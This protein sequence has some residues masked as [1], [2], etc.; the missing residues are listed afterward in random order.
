MRSITR[1]YFVLVLFAVLLCAAPIFA[2]TTSTGAIVGKAVDKTG[3][4]I[5]GVEV[6]ISSPAM[7]GG[8]RNAPTDETGSYRFTL[9]VAGAY[10]VSF[11]LPGF[12]TL[13]ID[14]VGVTPGATMTING[15]ME[16]STVAEEVTVTSETPA[17]DLQAATVGVNWEKQKLDDLPW[18]RSVVSLAQ[19]VPGIYVTNYDVGGNQMGGSSNI[20]GRVYG[21]SGGEVRTYDGVAWCMGFDDYGSYEEI[22]LSAAA[23]GAEAMSPGVLA[24]YVVKS[25]GNDFHGTGLAS[26]EDGSFQSSNVDATLLKDG[27]SPGSNNFTRY[28]QFDVDLGGPLVH[29]KLWFYGAYD[30]D[31]SGQYIA[32]FVSQATNAPFVYPITLKIPT[33]KLSYQLSANM[34]L[35]SMVQLSQKAAPYRTGSALVPAE[36]TQSQLTKTALGPTLKWTYIMSPKMTTEVGIERAGYWWPTVPHVNDSPYHRS[37][38]RANTRGLSGKLSLGQ[39]VGSGTVRGAG[40]PI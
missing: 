19:M 26:W 10:R 11:G 1:A 12:K 3:A 35:E 18:G 8:S 31:Y 24:T 25:G 20:G 16:V 34:K 36:A 15:T 17:I 22:Q 38:D 37:D 28:N 29:N 21:R 27:F 6:T 33:V 5:P 4:V 14:N 39:S 13:N 7:I 23:K 40:S 30:Y 2:Q 9:L 32:G